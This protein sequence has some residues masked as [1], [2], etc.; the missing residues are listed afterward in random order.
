MRFRT[1]Y[2]FLLQ[3][4]QY[5]F[6]V[7]Y[8]NIIKDIKRGKMMQ[9]ELILERAKN[10]S[11][12]H[13]CQGPHLSFCRHLSL[14]LSLSLSLTVDISKPILHWGVQIP[15]RYLNVDNISD[16]F[17]NAFTV[18]KLKLLTEIFEFLK[19]LKYVCRI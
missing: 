10:F 15:R 7:F 6:I 13:L 12:Q 16:L 19:F 3:Y 4:N 1:F 11:R 2:C 5:N 9:N 17:L 14:S 8:C 18:M